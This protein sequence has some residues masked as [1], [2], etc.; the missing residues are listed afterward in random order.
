MNGGMPD[1][2]P[3]VAVVCAF[4]APGVG[5]FFQWM[6][7]RRGSADSDAISLGQ[8]FGQTFRLIKSGGVESGTAKICAAVNL[9][10]T[11][12]ALCMVTL[13][14]NLLAAIF[15]HSF[16][17]LAPIAEAVAEKD[18]THKKNVRDVVR[19]FLLYQILLYAAAIGFFLATGSF[20][21]SQSGRQPGILLAETPFLTLALLCIAYT[22]LTR[23][24]AGASSDV[25]PAG[26]SG[27]GASLA[28][29]LAEVY[30]I[31]F[32]LVLA[33]LLLGG[34]GLNA[35]VAA[36]GIYAAMSWAG[37]GAVRL[38]RRYRVEL[39]WEYVLFAAGINLIWLYLKYM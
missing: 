26:F 31:G 7:A 12:L 14:M 5:L 4:L 37:P 39:R 35:V 34:R 20:T 21:I 19:E 11:L 29:I 36:A 8:A 27:G 2:L 33:G 15:L 1:L 16:A 30:R 28:T 32:F 38:L 23:N 13:Q 25:F 22:S 6:H 18:F 9:L 24:F 17:S 10:F 3:V